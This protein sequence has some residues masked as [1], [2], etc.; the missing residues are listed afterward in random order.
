M[1]KEFNE[2]VK[3]NGFTVIGI[4]IIAAICIY[5]V[6]TVHVE[7]NK[8]V[9]QCNEYWFN[10]VQTVCP[11]LTNQYNAAFDYNLSIKP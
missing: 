4:F 5:D 6:A 10:Q 8:L 3:K 11:V 9:N 7:K 2:W 1:L